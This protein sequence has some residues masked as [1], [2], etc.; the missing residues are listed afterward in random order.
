MKE[1]VKKFVEA[2]NRQVNWNHIILK[3]EVNPADFQY[4]TN[5]IIEHYLDTN[6]ITEKDYDLDNAKVYYY[7]DRQPVKAELQAFSLR[8]YCTHYFWCVEDMSE[9]EYKADRLYVVNDEL[10]RCKRE[11]MEI[12]KTAKEEIESIDKLYKL[13]NE[14]K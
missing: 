1:E 9:E 2:Y 11:Q 4:G 10:D 6:E 12:L 13:L 5:D 8:S 7:T 14:E 3:G